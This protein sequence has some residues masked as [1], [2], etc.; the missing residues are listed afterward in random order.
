MHQDLK[1][2]NDNAGVIPATFNCVWSSQS[3]YLMNRICRSFGF[4]LTTHTYIIKEYMN[5]D[6][7]YLLW[8]SLMSIVLAALIFIPYIRNIVQLV[9]CNWGDGR[10]AEELL[11]SI[12]IIM[13][14]LGWVLGWMGHF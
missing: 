3:S 9:H 8:L 6:A 1:I 7:K 12:G 2:N 5:Q 14:P 11:R 4:I 13:V 10:W